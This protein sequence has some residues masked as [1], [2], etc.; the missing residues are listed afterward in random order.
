MRLEQL[1]GA[2]FARGGRDASGIDCLGVALA[3]THQLGNPVPD[4]W[5]TFLEQWQSQAAGE[6]PPVDLIGFPKTWRRVE[7]ADDPR[8]WSRDVRQ[9]DVWCWRVR[10]NRMPGVGIIYNGRVWT[11][12]PRAGVVSLEPHKATKPDEVW[13][14]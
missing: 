10:P 6:R 3:G 5:L 12:T 14:P 8:A 7:Y 4:P 11:A 9:G 13:R 2:P 1:L